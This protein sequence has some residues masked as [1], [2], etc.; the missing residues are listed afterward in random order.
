[1]AEYFECRPVAA[2]PTAKEWPLV[3]ATS[4]HL[5]MTA[6]MFDHR[7]ASSRPLRSWRHC[8]RLIETAPSAARSPKTLRMLAGA[9]WFR[10]GDRGRTA[11]GHDQRPQRRS[12]RS[13]GGG[14]CA[15]IQRRWRRFPEAVKTSCRVSRGQL[16]KST[17]GRS[18]PKLAKPDSWPKAERVSAHLLE[19][20][21][22][23]SPAAWA[24]VSMTGG[25]RNNHR[26]RWERLVRHGGVKPVMWL[27]QAEGQAG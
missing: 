19:Q 16:M 26:G 12:R 13:W 17:G 11:S 6:R 25:R 15:P 3:R 4:R 5:K 10:P 22:L 14:C 23:I 20:H 18:D 9:G 24:I 27:E 7:I 1:M 2:G 21:G 8:G